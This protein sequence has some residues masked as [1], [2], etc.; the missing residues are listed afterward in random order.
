MGNQYPDYNSKVFESSFAVRTVQRNAKYKGFLGPS[1]RDDDKVPSVGSRAA[2]AAGVVVDDLGKLRCPP[3]TP[4]ANQFTDMQMSNCMVPG[5]EAIANAAEQASQ[6]LREL[7]DMAPEQSKRPDNL[8]QATVNPLRYEQ[9]VQTM[10]ADVLRRYLPDAK[11]DRPMREVGDELI[12]NMGLSSPRPLEE[13]LDAGLKL[14]TSNRE[15]ILS[16]LRQRLELADSPSS[17]RYVTELTAQIEDAFAK[18]ETPQGREELKTQMAE[19]LLDALAGQESVLQRFP[20]LRGKTQIQIYSSSRDPLEAAATAT[21]SV[22]DDGNLVPGIRYNPQSLI[23][24]G[25]F[26]TETEAGDIL[27]VAVRIAGVDS[28]QTDLA[29]H[30]MGHLVHNA[31]ALKAYGINIGSDKSVVDQLRENGETLDSTHLGMMFALRSGLSPRTNLQDLDA[32]ERRELAIHAVDRARFMQ[33]PIRTDSLETED[34]LSRI[35]S[36][37]APRRFVSGTKTAP[38]EAM[39]NGSGI[40]A[41]EYTDIPEGLET[42]EGFSSF[43][44][45][46][47]GSSPE[48]IMRDIHLSVKSD[49]GVDPRYVAT[50]GMPSNELMGVLGRSSRYGNTVPAEAV[51]ESFA[52]TSILSRVSGSTVE[53]ANELRLMQNTLARITREGQ[54]FGGAP[55]VSD[56]TKDAYAKLFQVLNS[57][58]MQNLR[59]NEDFIS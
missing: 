1:I 35:A 38:L 59:Q 52:L 33:D 27:D 12:K 44:K 49:L 40:N 34:S 54:E 21:T 29:V 19:N 48:Q 51:A 16:N 41:D 28:Y 23:I 53:D 58:E 17:R 26:D 15:S 57:A 8:F 45:N 43:V 36:S 46:L 30:E 42:P 22:D 14:F 9:N 37:V 47:T 39:G 13:Q 4:N 50:G 10:K 24:P 31:S 11:S 25:I 6:S 5:A 3:G 7:A 18:V 20:E 2:R 56:K 55:K 32:T